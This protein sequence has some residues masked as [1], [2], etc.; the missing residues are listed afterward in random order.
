MQR[1]KHGSTGTGLPAVGIRLDP[2]TK[3]WFENQA[4]ILKTSTSE[5]LRDIII[6]EKLYYD[7]YFERLLELHLPIVVPGFSY[8]DEDPENI[9]DE[10]IQKIIMTCLHRQIRILNQHIA[11]FENRISEKEHTAILREKC[12]LAG[13][14]GIPG[15]AILK[16]HESEFARARKRKDYA[17]Y[18]R[19]QVL[20][21]NKAEIAPYKKMVEDEI[22]KYVKYQLSIENMPEED[23]PEEEEWSD[24]VLDSETLDLQE[25]LPDDEGI[26][27]S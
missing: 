14:H 2:E 18:L 9:K 20:D 22:R 16:Y 26:T 25:K 5:F 8:C 1:K 17:K 19:A 11:Y 15:T 12:G 21:R 13:Y 10:T 27:S 3:E 7:S 4:E 24:R 6:K 23:M